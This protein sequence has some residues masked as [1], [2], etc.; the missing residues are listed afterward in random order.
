MVEEC[1]GDVC[2]LV[3]DTVVELCGGEAWVFG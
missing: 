2:E 3:C 1:V